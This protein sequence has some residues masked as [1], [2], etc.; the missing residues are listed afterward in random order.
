MGIT[1]FEKVECVFVF[2]GKF[3][4]LTNFGGEGAIEIGLVEQCLLI[5]LVLNLVNQ[6]VLCPTEFPCHSQ[7]KLSL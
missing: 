2:N 4:L 6:D 5:G 7:V 1:E 3:G